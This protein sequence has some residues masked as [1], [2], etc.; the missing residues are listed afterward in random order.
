MLKFNEKTVEA[1]KYNA[2]FIILS[3][4]LI[5][6]LFDCVVN[7]CC[8][9]IPPFAGNFSAYLEVKTDEF[10][11]EIFDELMKEDFTIKE[12]TETYRQRLVEELIEFIEAD[13]EY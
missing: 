9:E 11:Y 5:R 12:I 2:E 7:S 4:P 13:I 8:N 10:L 1:L 3:D 6:G